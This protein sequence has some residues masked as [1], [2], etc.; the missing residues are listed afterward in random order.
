MRF[1]GS[2]AGAQVFGPVPG[3][4]IAQDTA[5][6]GQFWSPVL[7][8]DVATIEFHAGPGVSDVDALTLTLP[9]I[10]HQM[11]GNGELKS[12][13]AKTVTEIGQAQSCNI[14]VACVTPTVALYNARKAVAQLLFVNDDGSQYLCTGTLLNTV[15]TTNTPYLFT[16][17]HCMKS[18]KAAHTLNTLWFFDAVE[19][20]SSAVPQYVQLTGGAA[21]LGRSQDNDWALVRL[22]ESPPYGV[23]YAAWNADPVPL[24]SVTTT[25]H[26]PLGDLKK[27]SEGYVGQSVSLSDE[28]VHGDFNEVPYNSGITEGGSSGAALLTYAASGGYYEV[29]G[30]ISEGN[31][32]TCP[33]APGAVFDDYSRMQDMLPLVRQ[34][35]TPEAPNPAGQVVAVEY[36]N[37]NLDHYF[38]TAESRRAPGSRYRR[39]R[40]LGTHGSALPRLR[41]PRGRH[42]SRVPLLSGTG[43]RRLALLFRE[44]RRMCRDRGGAPRRLDL[45]E[46]RGLLH[47]ATRQSRA[48]ARKG[49]SRCG[50]SSTRPRSIIATRRKS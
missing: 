8:G 48:P 1:A 27:W 16:A 39:A 29:R 28:V 32:A 46:S 42:E 50:G 33:A 18:A 2:A 13:S 34:F 4:A 43:V 9:R 5:R 41:R 21:L 24:T 31:L 38:L 20:H 19:C 23:R 17:G 11:V 40:R 45:R 25:L 7:A 26:H 12:L 47:P 30:G 36:Y 35:L 44:S 10:A 6:F 15:P 37:R 14:D 49:L 3:N 22:N